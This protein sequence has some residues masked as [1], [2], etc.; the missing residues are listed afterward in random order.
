M[1]GKRQVTVKYLVQ[2]AT[3]CFIAS[4][5]QVHVMSKSLPPKSR[6]FGIGVAQDVRYILNKNLVEVVNLLSLINSYLFL[7]GRGVL[8]HHFLGEGV[9]VPPNP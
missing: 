4:L 9:R 1:H 5:L 8:A 7:T 3:L 2:V 6:R